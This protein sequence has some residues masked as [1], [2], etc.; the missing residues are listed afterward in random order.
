MLGAIIGDIEGS[1]YEFH[2]T[3]DYNFE[4]FPA[5][6]NFADDTVCTI[7]IADALLRGR[8]FGECL[9]D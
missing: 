2:S 5:E 9:H 6:A 7:A 1:S 8:D 4:L 3:N